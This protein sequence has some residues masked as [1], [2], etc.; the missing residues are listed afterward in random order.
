[1]R[2]LGLGADSEADSW[3]ERENVYAKKMLLG[4]TQVEVT[5]DAVFHPIKYFLPSQKDGF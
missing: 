2:D 1:V 5:R 4:G 3:C